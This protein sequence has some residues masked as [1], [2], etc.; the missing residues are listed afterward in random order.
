[1]ILLEVRFGKTL[2][3]QQLEARSDTAQL[4]RWIREGV[5]RWRSENPSRSKELDELIAEFL[6]SEGVD[7][8]A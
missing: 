4:E 6:V 1:M 8:D 2:L 3:W 7:E 5:D